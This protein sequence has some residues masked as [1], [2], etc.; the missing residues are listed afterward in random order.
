MPVP[1]LPNTIHGCITEDFFSCIDG[2]YLVELYLQ[3]VGILN[4]EPDV[5]IS[6]N[7]TSLI[8]KYPLGV[9]TLDDNEK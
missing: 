8:R 2:L 5:T 4:L 1:R 3:F 7:R 6:R 9:T